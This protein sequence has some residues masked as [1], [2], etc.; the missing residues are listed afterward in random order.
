M[1]LLFT[2]ISKNIFLLLCLNSNNIILLKLKRKSLQ[3]QQL[4][5]KILSYSSL[6][7]NPPPVGWIKA[8]RTAVGMSLEQL[9]NRLSITKQSARHVEIR[10]QDGSITL[11]TLRETAAAMDMQLV[12][13]FIPNDGSLE[14]LIERKA[15]ELATQIVMRTS[16]SMKLEDQE[17]SKQRIEKAIQ[18]RA[19][20]IK[21]EMPK[22]LWD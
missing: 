3:V 8:V 17:N 16:N 15:T 20:E 19:F 22:S 13:A 6:Q 11:N 12:Y 9:G 10:E 21:Q 7:K 5:A 18:E 14:A 1:I 4:D 2:N